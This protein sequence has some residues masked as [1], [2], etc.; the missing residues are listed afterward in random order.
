MSGTHQTPE[1]GLATDSK[2]VGDPH[3]SG[4]AYGTSLAIAFVI[5]QVK[6]RLDRV[7]EVSELF[8]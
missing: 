4:E 2:R 6:K 5:M 8:C 7:R 3:G 1:H